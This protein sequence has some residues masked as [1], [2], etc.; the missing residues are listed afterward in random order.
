MEKPIADTIDGYVNFINNYCSIETSAV[1]LSY[2]AD[3]L[4]IKAR[5]I[6]EQ[7]DKQTGIINR[8]VY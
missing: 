8:K 4:E 2:L 1:L 7:A 6:R 3:T 5:K